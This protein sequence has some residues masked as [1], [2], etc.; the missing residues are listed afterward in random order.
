[1]LKIRRPLGRLIF[2]MGIAIPGKTVFLIE[3]APCVCFKLM[4]RMICHHVRGHLD[5]HSIMCK[6]QHGFWT[7]HSFVTQL[8]NTVKDLTMAYDKHKQI[9]AAAP[10]FSKAFDVV[11]HQ[12]LLEKLQHSGINGHILKWISGFLSGRTQCVV[13]DGAAS[14]W[15]AVTLGVSQATV[16][17]P[18]CSS[19]I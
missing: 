7:G 2:N 17:G 9:N 6:V 16:F 8:L 11:P 18:Y 12:R 10:D 15:S 19:Y 1:M 5:H 4:E 3:T 13:V 14:S